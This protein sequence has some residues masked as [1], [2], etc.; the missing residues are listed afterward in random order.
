MKIITPVDGTRFK[1]KE[2]LLAVLEGAGCGAVTIA[3]MRRRLRI[4]DIVEASNG[5]LKLRDADYQMLKTLFEK[6]QFGISHKELV[7]IADAVDQA[8]DGDTVN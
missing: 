5:V 8:T 2:T 7:D 6:H 1:F 4:A 3:E